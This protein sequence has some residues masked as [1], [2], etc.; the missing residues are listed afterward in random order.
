MIKSIC[1]HIQ[2]NGGNMKKGDY[3]VIISIIVLIFTSL[4]FV[5]KGE[6]DKG[7]KTIEISIDG[8]IYK[9]IKLDQNYDQKIEIRNEFGHNLIHIH[10]GG[11]EII[12][13]DC[14]EKI[15]I[16]MGFI[17]RRGQVLACLPHKLIIKILGTQKEVDD[18]AN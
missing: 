5:G 8:K 6:L 12:D 3:L 14:S 11:V 13:A 17:E 18:V 7:Q 15:G 10:D 1:K 9:R 16:K 2:K 4:G